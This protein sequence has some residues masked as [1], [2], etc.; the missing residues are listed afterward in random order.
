MRIKE[1]IVVSKLLL[2]NDLIINRLGV[3]LKFINNKK[4]NKILMTNIENADF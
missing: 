4:I 3:F 2:N 1:K